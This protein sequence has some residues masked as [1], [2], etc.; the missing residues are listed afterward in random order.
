MQIIVKKINSTA[1]LEL[2]SNLINP[3]AELMKNLNITSGIL[4]GIL[5]SSALATAKQRQNSQIKQEKIQVC[6]KA[7]IVEFRQFSADKMGNFSF[8]YP[9]FKDWAIKE[10]DQQINEASIF[11]N[12]PDEIDF[13]EAPRLYIKKQPSAKKE[14]QTKLHKSLINPNGVR[15]GQIFDLNM[16]NKGYKPAKD[17]WTHYIF[18]GN[19]F[20]ILMDSNIGV[21]ELS[22]CPFDDKIFWEKVVNTFKW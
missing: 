4:F 19:G 10:V 17:Q 8:T 18:Y 2:Q 14:D 15:Y 11:F 16:Y 3:R 22:S 21:Y 20:D 6:K 9:N 1:N 7:I 13:Y 12:Y 5:S